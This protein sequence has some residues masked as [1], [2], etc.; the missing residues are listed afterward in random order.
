MFDLCNVIGQDNI[1]IPS[2]HLRDRLKCATITESLNQT[3]DMLIECEGRVG[4]EIQQK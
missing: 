1:T 3:L 4:Q 2:K